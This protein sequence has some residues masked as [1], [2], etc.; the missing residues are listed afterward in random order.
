MS[1]F[2]RKKA[3]LRQKDA[4]TAGNAAENTEN[5]AESSTIG[6]NPTI[7]ELLRFFN[8]DNIT[9]ITADQLGSATYYACMLIRCNAIAKLPIKV[10]IK[11]QNGGSRDMTE[12]SLYNIL[13]RRPNPFVSPHDFKWAT[14]FQRLHFGNAYWVK[15]FRGGRFRGLYLLDST[16]VDIIVDNAGI[17]GNKNGIYYRYSPEKGKTVYYKESQIVHLK[18]FATDGIVGHSIRHH[19][20]RLID[21]EQYGQNVV[22]EK[23]KSGLQDPLIVTYTGDFDQAK[24]KKI[25]KRFASMGGPKNAGKVIPIPVDFKVQQLET[26][27]VNSQFFELS[28]LTTRQIANAFGVKSFQLNDLEKS[29]YNNITQQNAAFY[30]DTLLNVITAYEEEMSYKLLFD[31]E[32]AQGIYVQINPDVMLRSDL[33]TRYQAYQT[34]INSGFMEI[35]E[36]RAKEDMPFKPGTDKLII[37]NGASI[38]LDQ[39]G[40]QYTQG[41]G[42]E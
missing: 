13:H 20:S 35:A 42:E 26:K 33:Q 27:L 15:D 17:L 4:E 30:S 32:A 36:V 11:D 23:N 8:T 29:T 2:N 25:Q 34:A 16:R 41:G 6:P 39:L 10:K 19:L 5:N 1:I 7:A 40:N 18:N 31:E 3:A 38:P 22:A 37:G 12:H 9:N 21:N 14:E 28:T 24:I